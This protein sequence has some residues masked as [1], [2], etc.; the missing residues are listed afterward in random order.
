MKINETSNDNMEGWVDE[1]QK[2]SEDKCV[3]L[4]DEI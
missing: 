4:M 1:M 2:L 3:E